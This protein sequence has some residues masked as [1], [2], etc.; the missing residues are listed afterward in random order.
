MADIL[1]DFNILH[2]EYDRRNVEGVTLYSVYIWLDLYVKFIKTEKCDHS[3]GNMLMP[4]VQ[5]Q[6]C[7]GL[8][9]RSII[10]S[11]TDGKRRNTVR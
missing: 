7:C 1:F 10:T 3:V 5:L 9:D 4:I 8:R 2:D 6:N 11:R